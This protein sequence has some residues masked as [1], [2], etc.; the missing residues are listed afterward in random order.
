MREIAEEAD[1]SPGNLYYYFRGKDELL[2]F[3]QDRTLDQMHAAV[4]RARA[5]GAPVAAQLH[6][7][8]GAHLH[9]TL[10]EL[11]GATAHLE[12]EALPEDLRLPILDKRDRYE[13][14][15]RALVAKG[16]KRGE[17]AACDAALVT[18]AMLGAV[19]WAARWYRPEGAQTVAQ[20]ARSLSDYL[21]RGLIR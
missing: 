4:G 16:V 15:I 12:V 7:V 10:D 20:I 14:A 13:R 18:R 5:S 21:V 19:N 2:Y 1:L 9:C 6:A 17:F 11:Q 3:C 8:L